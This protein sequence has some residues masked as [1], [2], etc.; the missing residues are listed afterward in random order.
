MAI[1]FCRCRT[2]DPVHHILI[3]AAAIICHGN[4]QH[5]VF[6]SRINADIAIIAAL[7]AMDDGIFYQRLQDHLR[8]H[9]FF[10]HIRNL[11]LIE[12]LSAEPDLLDADIAVYGIQL[13]SQGDERL[14]GNAFS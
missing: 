2:V 6:L 13:L 11:C 12:E 5:A 9:A 10:Q 7:K 8:N 4:A 14:A 3:H 1:P